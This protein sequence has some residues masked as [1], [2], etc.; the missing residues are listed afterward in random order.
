[1]TSGSPDTAPEAPEGVPP[2]GGLASSATLEA[3]ELPSFL[4]V[5][6]T[7]CVTD[8]GRDRAVGLRPIGDTGV[9]E[10]RRRRFREARRLMRP[11]IVPSF[12]APLGPLLATLRPRAPR[13]PKGGEILALANLLEASRTAIARIRELDPPAEALLERIAPLPDFGSLVGKIRRI[14]DRRGEIREDATPELADLRTRI[15]RQ[16]DH[17]YEELQSLK[18]EHGDVLSEDTIPVRDGRLMLVLEAGAKGRIPGLVHGKSGSGRSFYFEPLPVVEANNELQEASS[19]AEEEK[20]RILT[21]LIG[22]LMERRDEIDAHAELLAELDLLQAAHRFAEEVDARLAD[23]AEDRELELIDARHPLLDPSLAERRERSLGAAGHREAVVPLSF[24]LDPER[25][26][27]VITGPNAGGKTV[28][29]KTTGLLALIHACGLPVPAGAG[30][31]IPS[32]S[33]VVGTVGD[34]QDLLAERSTFSGRLLRLDEAWQ[35]ADSRS[36]ILL[37]ELGSGTDPEEGAAL[38][39][40]LLEG[41]LERGGL[42]VITTHLTPVA[43]EAMESAGAFCAAMEF[44]DESGEPL[45]RLRP[46][47]PGSSEALALARRLGLDAS[48]L[49]AAEE[50]LGPEGLDYRRLLSDVEGLRRDLSRELEE[51]RDARE[52]ARAERDSVLEEKERLEEER[53]KVG[54]RLRKELEAFRREVRKKIGE[55]V[56][57]LREELEEGRRKGLAAEATER[58]FEP[59]PEIPS[60]EPEPEGTLEPGVQ[61]RHRTLGWT[62]VLEDRKRGRAVVDVQGKRLRCGVD[63]LIPQGEPEPADEKRPAVRFEEASDSDFAPELNLI[64]ERVEPAL[65][66]LDSYLDRALLSG[67]P[68]VRIVH[69]HGTGRLRSAVREHLEGH[70]AVGEWRRGRRREGGNGA[71]VVLFE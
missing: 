67:R 42:V 33:S 26:V 62:G 30:T 34:E 25:R 35:A 17:L 69:G 38:A 14:L 50:R 8:L 21:E 27:L 43:A 40:A 52:R 20:R 70:R 22:E 1:M 23:P 57:S 7:Y 32:L 41:L 24:S 2:Q 11:S 59:S 58:L 29:L 28:A 39:G 48:L 31:R 16:R 60:D 49:T 18:R 63:D 44:D 13:P 55:E 66:R 51:A 71:T 65:R 3:L 45:Y 5:F 15:R 64:G 36:L 47:A 6:G 4:R 53:R 56:E 19:A 12:E 54:K 61:V 68:E 9:L 46:G 10:V 37:D